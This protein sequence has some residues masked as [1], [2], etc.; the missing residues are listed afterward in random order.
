M[1]QSYLARHFFIRIGMTRIGFAYNEKPEPPEQVSESRGENATG[2]DEPPSLS[3]HST[4]DRY[5]EWDSRETIDA[6]ARA[7]AQ[8]G[9]VIRLEATQEFP[10]RLREEAPDI[11]FNIAEGLH[12]V[13][14][15]SHVPAI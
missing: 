6:V 13:N 11:V 14:R 15:E 3:G 5:A 10:Q 12:G 4:D 7:L 1:G 8:C 9:E 2:E